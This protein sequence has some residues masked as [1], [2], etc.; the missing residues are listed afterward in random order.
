MTGR[1]RGLA[2]RLGQS[3]AANLIRIWC[4]LHKLD[5][6]MRRIFKKALDEGFYSVLKTVIGHLHRQQNLIT[7][8]RS[9]CP[10]IA[11]VCCISMELS[12][13]CLKRN[14]IQLQNHFDLKKPRC[15]PAKEWRLFTFLFIASPDKLRLCSCLFKDSLFCY[16]SSALSLMDASIHTA[17]TG[18]HTTDELATMDKST[19]EICGSFALTHSNTRSC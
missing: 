10:L 7:S 18:P 4:G 11:D 1:A 14:I 3:K 16:H 17:I 15:T 12:L 19:I 2:K 8:M 6:V 13:T 9:T 5:L